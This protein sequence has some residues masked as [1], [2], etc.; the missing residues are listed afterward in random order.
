M[1]I[2]QVLRVGRVLVK[3]IGLG[4]LGLTSYDPVERKGISRKRY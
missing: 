3:I 4:L 1:E 2:K